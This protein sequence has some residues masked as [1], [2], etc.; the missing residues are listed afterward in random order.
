[1][2]KLNGKIE[3]TESVISVK[4]SDLKSSVSLIA[5]VIGGAV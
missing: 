5:L 2:S 1:M 4:V 3:T